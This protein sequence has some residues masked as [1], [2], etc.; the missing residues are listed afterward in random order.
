MSGFFGAKN[1]SA[2]AQPAKIM[3]NL[4][5]LLLRGH[6]ILVGARSGVAGNSYRPSLLVPLWSLHSRTKVMGKDEHIPTL[7]CGRD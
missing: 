7:R 1:D 4:M 6:V 2:E 3:S 5:P